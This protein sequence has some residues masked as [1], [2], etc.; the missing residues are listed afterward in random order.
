MPKHLAFSTWFHCALIGPISSRDQHRFFVLLSFKFSN[1]LI[2][3]RDTGRNSIGVFHLFFFSLKHLFK[4][5]RSF[6]FSPQDLNAFQQAVFICLSANMSLDETISPIAH[7]LPIYLSAMCLSAYLSFHS[8]ICSPSSFHTIFFCD[9]LS[10]FFFSLS[11][12]LCLLKKINRWL[13]C[14]LL[15]MYDHLTEWC[16][17][18]TQ[19]FML[20]QNLLTFIHLSVCL[21]YRR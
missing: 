2:Q 19:N 4:S 11:F 21:T 14:M 13:F 16:G 5:P 10:F 20:S 3:R 6:S 15:N 18:Y 17:L 1:C 12:L 8:G 9:I 7:C